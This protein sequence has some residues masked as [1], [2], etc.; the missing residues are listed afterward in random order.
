[1]GAIAQ[2]EASPSSIILRLTGGFIGPTRSRRFAIV[3]KLLTHFSM[4][5]DRR[6]A[7]RRPDERFGK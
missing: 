6:L 5:I 1:V 3:N 4:D 2:D 7:N